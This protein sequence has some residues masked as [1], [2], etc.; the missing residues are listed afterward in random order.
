MDI[1]NRYFGIFHFDAVM[2][3]EEIMIKMYVTYNN[4]NSGSIY[5]N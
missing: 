3:S 5:L 1:L 2:E 4:V